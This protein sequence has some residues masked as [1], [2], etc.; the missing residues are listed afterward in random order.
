MG[1]H[2][3][4][5]NVMT[6]DASPS[7]CPTRKE[8]SFLNANKALR[9]SKWQHRPTGRSH[10]LRGC[11]NLEAPGTC[12]LFI[13][14]TCRQSTP[15]V[16]KRGQFCLPRRQWAT[17][18]DFL[19]GR[20]DGGEYYWHLTRRSRGPSLLQR[21]ALPPQTSTGPPHGLAA[22]GSEG[23]DFTRLMLG[24]PGAGGWGGGHPFAKWPLCRAQNWEQAVEEFTTWGND[25]DNTDVRSTFTLSPARG[26]SFKG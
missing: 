10:H 14:E 24:F 13:Q 23:Q 2:S 6:S 7:P 26:L 1:W 15:G 4:G 11:S 25:G 12:H 22:A 9:P 5:Q 20:G 17:A 18:G 16:L 8:S 19:I 3:G 21:K